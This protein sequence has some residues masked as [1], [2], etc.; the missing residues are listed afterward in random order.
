MGPVPP[1]P[2]ERQTAAAYEAAESET[3]LWSSE[4][5]DCLSPLLS[6]TFQKVTTLISKMCIL[7]EEFSELGKD[8]QK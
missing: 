1:L 7:L 4:R 3:R 2:N 5:L 8:G 6:H